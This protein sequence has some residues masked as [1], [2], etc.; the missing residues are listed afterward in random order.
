MAAMPTSLP[1]TAIGSER[2]LADVACALA[3]PSAAYTASERA[4]IA[5]SE[6]AHAR[7]T[8][9]VRGLI[10]AGEDPLG[11]LF[12]RLRLPG[13]RRESGGAAWGAA[14]EYSGSSATRAEGTAAR[15]VATSAS[16]G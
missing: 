1:V 2:E 4:L 14:Y 9:T 15:T 11:D 8:E 10:A 13:T 5:K 6:A 16:E 7:L 12:C 3:G